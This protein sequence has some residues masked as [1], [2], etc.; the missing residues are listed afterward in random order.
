MAPGRQ[1][2]RRR[3]GGEPA[4]IHEKDSSIETGGRFREKARLHLGM[5][6]ELDELAEVQKETFQRRT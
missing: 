3:P 6:E 5:R 2:C 1:C 4:R